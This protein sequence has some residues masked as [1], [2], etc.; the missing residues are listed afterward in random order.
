M[1]ALLRLLTFLVPSN[2]RVMLAVGLGCAAVVTSTGL[3][4]VA[5]YL[6][7]AAAFRP[8]LVELAGAM[9]LVRVFGLTR[10]FTRYGERLVSHDVTFH[11]LARLRVWL[12]R[13]LAVLSTG[14][15]LQ[16]RSADL[17][18]RLIRD[19]D[20]TQNLFQMLVA[21]V[22][23]ATL[24]VGVIG[25]GFWQL[26]G[27]LGIT[28][29][30]FL[31]VLAAAIPLLAEVLAR[32]AARRQVALR[33]ALEI[34]VVDG[35]QGLPDLLMLGRAD[36]YV[37]R[38]RVR[39]RELRRAQRRAALIGGLRV[40]A[41][42]GLGRIGAWTVLLIAIP[43][44][45][46]DTLGAAYLASLA[47]IMLGAAEVLQPLAQA[48]QQLGRTRASAQR[49]WQVAD[50]TPAI[51]FPHTLAS[52]SPAPVLEFDHV[53]FS[54]NHVAVLH[55]ISFMLVPGHPVVL[56]GSSGA[57]KT[58][59]LQLATRAW[60][61]SIGEIRLDG[62]DL[63]TY[64]WQSLASTISSVAQD[65]YVFSA[66]LRQNLQLGGPTS[67]DDEMLSVLERVGLKDLVASLPRG[68][69][70]WVGDH[71]VRLSGGE[72]QRLA[73]ARTLLQ[74]TPVL[75]LDEPTANLDPVSERLVFD[76][77]QELARER[78]VLLATHRL[79]HLEWANVILVL[80]DGRIVERGS[81]ADLR[82]AG[83]AFERLQTVDSGLGGY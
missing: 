36:E 66:T 20:E 80:E 63:R 21:P 1:T 62:R 12:Y 18:G 52:Q 74:D 4:A 55:D 54:Y 72:R 75:L 3:L 17:L 46:T 44:I 81:Q 65:A 67:S 47:V 58:T 40:A 43:L 79:S 8:P 29:V 22:L 57:G 15:L 35:L 68:L 2:G 77:I 28:A 45:A 49:L 78:S 23:V 39:D 7:S 25:V 56:V 73:L 9:Y 61:P 14:Q 6:V 10:A 41:S 30:C 34:D 42:D 33:T 60:D 70:T 71:G 24:T 16:F 11:L 82:R 32:P 13:H 5:A 31:L 37:E 51:V 76:T 50:E 53:G 19:V 48:A 64:P 69:E 26:D 59:L 83:G 38:V 27:T